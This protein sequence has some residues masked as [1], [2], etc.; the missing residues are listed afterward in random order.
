MEFSTYKMIKWIKFGDSCLRCCLHRTMTVAKT[1]C[2]LEFLAGAGAEI[3]NRGQLPCAR[4]PAATYLH[5]KQDKSSASVNMCLVYF[6]F[7]VSW[8]NWRIHT[9]FKFCTHIHRID[10]NK[11]PLKFRERYSRGRCH[12]LPKIFRAPTYRA[13]RAVILAI[14]QFSCRCFVRLFQLTCSRSSC[15]VI[16]YLTKHFQYLWCNHLFNDVRRREWWRHRNER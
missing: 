15:D 2:L 10:G 13:H 9:N 3:T 11:R 4:L 8:S 5:P 16:F 12:I 14:A 1:R 6:I 7:A